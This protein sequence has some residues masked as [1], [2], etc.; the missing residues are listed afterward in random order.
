MSVLT[1]SCQTMCFTPD[2]ERGKSN[3]ITW[4]DP[5]AEEVWGQ[6]NNVYCHILD[7]QT[8]ETGMDEYEVELVFFN[9]NL[10][11]PLTEKDLAFD[12]SKSKRDRYIDRKVPRRAI[13]WNEKPFNDDEHLPNTFRH[14]IEF[15]SELVPQAWLDA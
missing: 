3:H 10:G 12:P 7:R 13:K 15:P 4:Y 6:S 9:D 5:P 14:P 2:F 8:G 1:I 11:K